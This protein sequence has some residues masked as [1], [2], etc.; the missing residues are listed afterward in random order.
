MRSLAD[1]D[2]PSSRQAGRAAL[3]SASARH[4]EAL[5]D[6]STWPGYGLNVGSAEDAQEKQEKRRL[7]ELVQRSSGHMYCVRSEDVSKYEYVKPILGKQGSLG[8]KK[9]GISEL[10]LPEGYPRPKCAQMQWGA[11][12]LHL[13]T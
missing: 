11:A 1:Y 7:I 4:R 12:P 10:D 6:A 5:I 8:F 2:T 9:G 13:R 3:V